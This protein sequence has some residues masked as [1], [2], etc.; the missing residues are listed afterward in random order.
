MSTST[1]LQNLLR[2]QEAGGTWR[3]DEAADAVVLLTCSGGEEMGMIACDAPDLR[4]YV[5]AATR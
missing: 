2:W 5:N 3:R 4:E 1:A